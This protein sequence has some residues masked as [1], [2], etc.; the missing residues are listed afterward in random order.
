MKRF[1]LFVLLLINSVMLFPKSDSLLIQLDNAITNRSFYESSKIER[2]NRIKR[3]L[4]N[5]NLSIEDRYKINNILFHEYESYICDS[6]RYYIDAN[7]KMSKRL[8]RVDYFIQALVKKA[9]ILATSGLYV[10]AMELLNSI[11][12]K[13]LHGETL[14]D[15][16][17]TFE[18]LYLYQAEYTQGDEYMQIYLK[19][20]NLYRDSA[21]SVIPNNSYLYIITK[22]PSLV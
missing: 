3:K 5:P 8:G 22:V 2:I 13:Y 17:I 20:M 1:F 18:N 9:H 6:A 7:I 16:Y 11:D 21:L 15:Y 4:Y 14:A 12:K 19:K 10:E